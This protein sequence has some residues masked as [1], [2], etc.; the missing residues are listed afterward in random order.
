[1]SSSAGVLDRTGCHS[2][3]MSASCENVLLTIS[4]MFATRNKYEERWYSDHS[5]GN[6]S[7]QS[8]GLY[9]SDGRGHLDFER[10]FCANST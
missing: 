8:H 6:L 1:M 4:H 5:R 7:R 9:F 2:T 3:H 10:G